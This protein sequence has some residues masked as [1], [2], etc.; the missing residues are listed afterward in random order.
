MPG[1]Y[2]HNP[3]PARAELLHQLAEQGW[4][5]D[6]IDTDAEEAGYQATLLLIEPDEQQELSEAFDREV[7]PGN[8]LL[9]RDPHGAV[10]LHEYATASHAKQA[11]TDLATTASPAPDDGTVTATGPPGSPYAVTLGGRRVG[12]A[13]SLQQAVA[14]LRDAIDAEPD[15]PDAWHVSDHGIAHRIDPGRVDQ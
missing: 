5:N 8:F 10:T 11:F 3:D 9:T 14:M 7:P 6:S 2:Q 12:S 1:Y 4:G 13:T 15:W